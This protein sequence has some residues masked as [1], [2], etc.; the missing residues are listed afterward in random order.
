MQALQVG[1]A[2]AVIFTVGAAMALYEWKRFTV[3]RPLSPGTNVITL[4]W[5]A[6][7]AALVLG[8]SLLF[9]ETLLPVVGQSFIGRFRRPKWR[10]VGYG[11]G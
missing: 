5:V 9:A 8:T 4:Y 1:G 11:G 7:L 10:L 2:G 3:G 6:Y